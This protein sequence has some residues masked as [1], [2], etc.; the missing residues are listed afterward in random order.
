MYSPKI[1]PDLIPMLYR[2]KQAQGDKPMTK[3]VDEILR[4]A[5]LTLHESLSLSDGEST[6]QRGYSN[7]LRLGLPVPKADR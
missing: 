4:P 3:I 5:V 6:G 2:I 1:K 7:P